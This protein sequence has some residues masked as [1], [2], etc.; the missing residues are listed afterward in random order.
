MAGD[1]GMWCGT[2][3]RFD[4]YVISDLFLEFAVFDFW[5]V[6]LEDANIC[7]RKP[8]RSFSTDGACSAC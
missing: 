2:L 5:A 1:T 4:F 7:E 3:W 8:G 6:S